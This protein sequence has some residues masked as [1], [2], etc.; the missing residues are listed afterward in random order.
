[1]LNNVNYDVDSQM[2][3]RRQAALTIRIL[4]IPL[5]KQRQ[6][7]FSIR[8]QQGQ[9]DFP[10]DACIPVAEIIGYDEISQDCPGNPWKTIWSGSSPDL[11]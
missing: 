3:R 5:K 6:C 4:E 2:R 10:I 1:V 8:I 7:G 11:H 9:C